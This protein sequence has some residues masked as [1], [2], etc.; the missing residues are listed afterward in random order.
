M[1]KMIQ[2]TGGRNWECTVILFLHYIR[3]SINECSKPKDNYKNIS[4]R[5]KNKTIEE[6]K[7]LF[8][9][10]IQKKEEK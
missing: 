10:S 1:T 6:I 4:H 8:K 7:G 9:F 2:S 3:C 5:Y